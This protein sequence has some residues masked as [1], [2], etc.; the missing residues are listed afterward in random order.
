MSKCIDRFLEAHN[1]HWRSFK[2]TPV[3]YAVTTK[4]DLHPPMTPHGWRGGASLYLRAGKFAVR[5]CYLGRTHEADLYHVDYAS[6]QHLITPKLPHVSVFSYGASAWV[7][8]TRYIPRIVH[9]YAWRFG[10]SFFF[11]ANP[12]DIE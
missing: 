6:R 9:A 1:W 12:W 10:C 4:N 5:L 3:K 11:Q 8:K 2:S 7:T